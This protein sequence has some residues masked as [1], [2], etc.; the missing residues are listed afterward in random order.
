MNDLSQLNKN[1]ENTKKSIKPKKQKSIGSGLINYGDVETQI[2][3]LNDGEQRQKCFNI[4][5]DNFEEI[6]AWIGLNISSDGDQLM[7]QQLWDKFKK[8]THISQY[9]RLFDG[10]KYLS[11]ILSIIVEMHKREK[12]WNKQIYDD[13][14]LPT[15]L[16]LEYD[17]GHIT[18][19][20]I[21][22]KGTA[23]GSSIKIQNGDY[24]RLFV[25]SFTKYEFE[26]N[27]KDWCQL[28]VNRR[29]EHR[30]SEGKAKPQE[31]RL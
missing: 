18:S 16:E 15:L 26:K 17:L 30:D 22:T 14:L 29:G 8:E 3:T 1:K 20:I 4:F 24:K 28:Y 12:N 2:S 31:M 19:W 9:Q 23:T 27:I 7:C 25:L 6:I 21:R 5:S 10:G 11:K 13:S